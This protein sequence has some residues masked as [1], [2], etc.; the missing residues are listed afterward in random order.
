MEP[1]F[2]CKFMGVLLEVY[3]NRISVTE[4]GMI[5]RK[6]STNILLRNVTSVILN[7]QLFIETADGRAY[8]YYLGGNTKKAY[9]AIMS[10]LE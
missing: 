4:G 9:D 6:V 10:V 7:V 3:P 5:S 2:S 8:K 1:I